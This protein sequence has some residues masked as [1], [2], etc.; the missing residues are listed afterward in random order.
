MWCA[1][2]M[3]SLTLIG[4]VGYVILKVKKLKVYKCCIFGNLLKVYIFISYPESFVPFELCSTA[5]H[6]HLF[7]KN[8]HRKMFPGSTE[9]THLMDTYSSKMKCQSC[10]FSKNI[11]QRKYKVRRIMKERI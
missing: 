10:H 8:V 9:M 11:Y 7:I 6:L 4:E 1:Y 2:P 5:G 3:I